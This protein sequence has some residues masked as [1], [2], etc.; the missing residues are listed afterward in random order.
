MITHVFVMALALVQQPQQQPE[1][2]QPSPVARI[3]ITPRVREVVAGDSVRYEARAL[4]A[5]GKVVQSA[6][7]SFRARGGQGEGTIDTTG[8]VVASSVGKMPISVIAL[9]PGARPFVD[10]TFELRM[11]PG[12]AT[13]I[14][15][16]VRPSKLVGGQSLLV[17]AVPFS[18]QNDRARDA[19]RWTWSA[20]AIV[21]VDDAGLITAIAPGRATLTARAAQAQT[22][23]AVQVI[24]ATLSSV[25]IKPTR[26]NV[27][28]GD[29][30]R[31]TVDAKDRSGAAVSG[32]SPT[33]SF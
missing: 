24:P 4:D 15:I 6:R 11:I 29:V 23:V 27:R 31:F 17:T 8:K 25:S 10:S 16:P 2:L 3:E 26:S 9:V 28:T 20:P 18:R 32:L 19:V 14:D 13:R 22:T 1:A 5:S 33:W 30:V 12:P 7:V 21:R